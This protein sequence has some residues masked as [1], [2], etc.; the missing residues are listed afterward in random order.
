MDNKKNCELC[1]NC[2]FYASKGS[3]SDGHCRRYAPKTVRYAHSPYIEWPIVKEHD[4]CGEFISR[5][6]R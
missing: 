6:G 2:K 5:H 1:K 3:P 4:W